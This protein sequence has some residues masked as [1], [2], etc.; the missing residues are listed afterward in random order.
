M[1]NK[2]GLIWGL[3]LVILGVIIAL[4]RLNITNINIFFNGWWTL[5][6]I[7]PSFIGLFEK[8]GRISSIIFLLIGILLLLNSQD[9]I[10][11]SS[12]SKLILPII[13]VVVGLSLVFKNLFNR[14]D[15]PKIKND[16]EYEAVFSHQNISLDSKFAGCDLNAVFGALEFDLSNSNIKDESVINVCSIF[17]GCK[18]KIPKD[19]NV[20]SKVVTIFGSLNNKTKN[21]EKVKTTIYIGGVTLFGGVEIINDEE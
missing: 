5:F 20:S 17:G 15:I 8:E 18:I 2:K 16:K 21:T 9:I 10:D 12:V 7:V 3:V 1:E 13:L 14:V 6:I 19:V 4:N 11:F